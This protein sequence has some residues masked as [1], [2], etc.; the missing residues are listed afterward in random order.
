MFALADQDGSGLIE[1]DEFKLLMR[2][3]NPD[4][5]DPGDDSAA[6]T[7]ETL[8]AIE[9]DAPEDACQGPAEGELILPP[10][11]D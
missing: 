4:G 6:S 7:K 3:M 1:Y 5:I 2:G 11:E 10:L 9:E 8:P